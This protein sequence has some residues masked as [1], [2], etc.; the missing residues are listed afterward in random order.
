MPR[1]KI[2]LSQLVVER[3]TVWIEANN[4]DEAEK[5]ALAESAI[6]L[7]DWGFADSYD[8]I[9]VVGVEEIT[10]TEITHDNQA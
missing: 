1:Y 5:L 9:E 10:T 7:A 2:T 4:S 8:D 3:A 6:S